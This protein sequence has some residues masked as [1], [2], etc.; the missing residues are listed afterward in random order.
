MIW[1]YT[2]LFSYETVEYNSG[3]WYYCEDLLYYWGA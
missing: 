3:Q 1:L 2:E